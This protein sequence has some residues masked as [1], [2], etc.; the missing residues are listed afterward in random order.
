MW[1]NASEDL[2]VLF[3]P[4]IFITPIIPNSVSEPLPS[5]CLAACVNTVAVNR[6]YISNSDNVVPFV[7]LF[8]SL[9]WDEE[10][11]KTLEL[12]LRKG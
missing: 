9:E 2:S 8:K 11:G 5:Y 10:A 4:S 7:G 3:T 1:S 12:R 6:D